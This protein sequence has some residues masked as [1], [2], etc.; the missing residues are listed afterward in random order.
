MQ[1]QG[2]FFF[3]DAGEKRLNPES[4]KRMESKPSSDNRLDK[5]SSAQKHFI[6]KQSKIVTSSKLEVAIYNFKRITFYDN[7][8]FIIT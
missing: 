5:S 8:N 3:I 1:A 6:F 7:I 2:F 4:T